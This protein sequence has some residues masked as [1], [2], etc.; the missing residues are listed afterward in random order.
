MSFKVVWKPSVKQGLASIWIKATNRRA[1]TQAAN[2][3]DQCL[4]TDPMSQGE[5][6]SGT[7]RILIVSPLAVAYEV[8]ETDRVVFVLSVRQL[9][10]RPKR[11]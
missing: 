6:R 8:D 11:G 10:D 5:S 7:T 4:E 1:V 3:I 2:K 9:P